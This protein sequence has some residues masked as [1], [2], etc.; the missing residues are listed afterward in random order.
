MASSRT[1]TTL[2]RTS[3]AFFLVTALTNASRVISKLSSINHLILSPKGR[4]LGGGH[5]RVPGQ[6]W[7]KGAQPPDPMTANT[8]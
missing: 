3:P 6:V 2:N 8:R 1:I 4:E 5:P 7:K